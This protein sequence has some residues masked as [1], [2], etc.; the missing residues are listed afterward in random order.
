MVACFSFNEKGSALNLNK[1]KL[2]IIIT[3]KLFILVA[4]S[5]L[6]WLEKDTGNKVV[7]DPNYI[8]AEVFVDVI[9]ESNDLLH[10]FNLALDHL[11]AKKKSEGEF[12]QVVEEILPRSNDLLGR[13]DSVLYDVDDSL[14]EFHRKFI[15]LTNFQHQIFL[16]S[17]RMVNEEENRIDKTQLRNDYVRVKTEQ[18][19]LVQEIKTILSDIQAVQD[20]EE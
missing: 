9:D 12:K 17:L 5:P 1:L 8:Y 16:E 6:D 3:M 4:C 20:M 11:Y 19:M 13:L 15:E 14:Y 2:S 7:E 18:T 10:E